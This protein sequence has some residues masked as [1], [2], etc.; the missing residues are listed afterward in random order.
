[1]KRRND[2]DKRARRTRMWAIIFVV[3][4]V[5]SSFGIMFSG[6]SNSSNEVDYKGQVFK[7][8]NG[9]LATSVNKVKLR[10]QS[11]PAGL[12]SIPVDNQS[13]EKLRSSKMIYLAFPVR[14][15]T[16]EYASLAAY[17][18]SEFLNSWKIYAVG[19]ISDNN[20]GY[21]QFP[22]ISCAN[23]TGGAPVVLLMEGNVS[24]SSIVGEG[25]CIKLIASNPYDYVALKDRLV[26][27]IA[28]I[29]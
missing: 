17:D 15:A 3:L 28:G 22:L 18:L 9:Y 21:E 27:R 14:G 23:A 2:S 24:R 19:G 1:M 13:I 10:I 6:F 4:M 8:E 12:A 16:P 25:D 20:T 29:D 5:A 7:Q 11:D 26:L